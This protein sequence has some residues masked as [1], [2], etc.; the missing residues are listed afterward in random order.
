MNTMATCKAWSAPWR[1]RDSQGLS[2]KLGWTPS[3]F[4][5]ANNS[6]VDSTNKLTL[7]RSHELPRCG[8]NEQKV[9]L[10]VTFLEKRR[11]TCST[12]PDRNRHRL[13]DVIQ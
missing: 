11:G 9:I 13:Q 7:T 3:P 2:H 4:D 8:G 1:R 5:T 10:P 12:I 6:I